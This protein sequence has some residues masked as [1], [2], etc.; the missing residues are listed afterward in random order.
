MKLAVL[1]AGLQT[2]VQDLGRDGHQALGVGHAGAMDSVAVRL[3]NLLVGNVENTAALEIAISGPT[4]RLDADALIALTGADIDARVDAIS[5]PPWRPV[6][7][8]A[9]SVL[10]L[11]ATRNGARSYLAVAGGIDIDPVLGSRSTDV[12]SGLGAFAGRALKVGD[13]LPYR[14]PS[15][16]IL[17]ALRRESDAAD[18]AKR[19]VCAAHWSLDP[20]PWFDPDPKHPL[21]AIAG[22]HFPYLDD[23]SRRA[24]FAAQFR[25]GAES[26]RVGYRLEGPA[27]QFTQTLELVTEGVA[28]GTVQLPSGGAPIVLM[29]EAPTSG[30]Y[31]RIAQVIALDLPRLAQRRPG[32]PLRFAE[33]SLDE[34]QTR[35]LERERILARLSGWIAERLRK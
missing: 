31:P 3:A 21:R 14:S 10:A 28:P 26:N 24:L 9:G 5:I 33:I 17:P 16:S 23:A 35:Y 1:K 11:G 32:E 12:N 29:A 19:S 8:R 34:A 30:G 22:S 15:R 20:T 27:L 2:S 25:V 18:R 13:V 7:V 4:L 6:L